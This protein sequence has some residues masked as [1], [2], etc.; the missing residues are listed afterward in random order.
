MIT[1]PT[2]NSLEHARKKFFQRNRERRLSVDLKCYCVDLTGGLRHAK[3]DGIHVE[4]RVLGGV[5]TM[6]HTAPQVIAG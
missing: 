5:A 4:V 6:Q 1:M 2:L 3:N